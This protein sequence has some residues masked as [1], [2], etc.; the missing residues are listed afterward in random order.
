[1]R[2]YWLKIALGS[3]VI[4]AVGMAIASMVNKGRNA[5]HD[6]AVGTGP[7]TVPLLGAVP[8]VLDGER[9][10][11][12]SQLTMYRS[13][14]KIPS[15]FRVVVSLPDSVPSERLGRCI[16][17]VDPE[18]SSSGRHFDINAKTAFRCLASADTAGK[19]L[20]PF[21][22][23][24]IRSRPDSVP[25]LL[26]RQVIQDIQTGDSTETDSVPAD[27]GDSIAASVHRAMDS[28][29]ASAR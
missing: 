20:E 26:P 11:S 17:L 4:F 29:K 9:L 22:T 15:S 5:V 24:A 21:G 2:N 1:M 25:F 13:A 28:A 6:L 18:R 27:L 7:I 8:F 16:I 14:P 12:V 23:L 3:L 19:E 10:G